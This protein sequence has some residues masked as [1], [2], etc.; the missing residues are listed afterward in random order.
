MFSNP[1][2]EN[3]FI[4]YHTY[5]FGTMETKD[6]EKVPLLFPNFLCYTGRYTF[7]TETQLYQFPKGVL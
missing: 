7:F 5:P 6:P 3:F 1:Q 2:G 4:V